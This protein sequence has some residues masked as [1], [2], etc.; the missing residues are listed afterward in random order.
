MKFLFLVIAP[1]FIVFSISHSF[2][3]KYLDLSTNSIEYQMLQDPE[4]FPLKTAL[5]LAA[6]VSEDNLAGY[7]QQL[8]R[9]D[10]GIK[11]SRKNQGDYQF[12]R[13]AFQ[14]MHSNLLKRYDANTTTLD[15]ALS[16]GVFNCLSSTA[17]YSSILEDFKIPF[18]I[19]V[20][21]THIYSTLNLEGREVDVENT[22]PYGFD[23][24]TNEKAQ[25][26]LKRN[27]GFTYTRADPNLEMAG[28]RGMIA[29]TYAN[30]SYFQSKAGKRKE[31]F[32]SA[33][34]SIVV[35][36]EGRQIYTNAVA[37]YCEYSLYLAD[38]EKKFDESLSILE[39]AISNLPRKEI[40]ITNYFYV[41]DKYISALTDAGKD[42]EAFAVYDK[43]KKVV[44]QNTDVEDALFFRI[45]KRLTQQEQ[46]YQKAYDFTKAEMLTNQM[47][48]GKISDL[49]RQNFYYAAEQRIIELNAL[50]KYE[51]A[52]ALYE[53]AVK[54]A[55]PEKNVADNL[56]AGILQSL[57]DKNA[58]PDLY[59]KYVKIA[60]AALPDSAAVRN[61]I[62]NYTIHIEEK[63]VANWQTYPQGLDGL[64]NWLTL[65]PEKKSSEILQNYFLNIGYHF[66]YSGQKDKG[67]EITRKGF[68][69]FPDSV[70]LKRNLGIFLYNL[71]AVS[72]NQHDFRKAI[73]Q[74]KKVLEV[75]PG[76]EQATVVLKNSYL[77]LILGMLDSKDY[78]GAKKMD[79]DAL[80]DFPNDSQFLEFRNVINKH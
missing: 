71:A 9:F 22:T 26:E 25:E 44:G 8:N 3:S 60:Q 30:L 19:M 13:T 50:G 75:D 2:V 74:A 67:I 43:A 59:H 1:L 48:R 80:K 53:D 4:R 61:T 32:Q 64:T 73:G 77:A 46:D 58:D 40:F 51:D 31:A 57:S 17:L 33:L 5:L 10:D 45:F 14:M 16:T 15:V 35:F 66:Y 12:A 54:T 47:N 69:L 62:I 20:L 72:F 42:S 56:Y 36:R 21:P 34:K 28:K 38:Y 76:N 68:E 65:V 7:L 70:S 37:S 18:F 23:I 29:Y 27:T 6:G 24:S 41:L 52:I 11:E 78:S 79:D 49:Y 39:D 55:G 63:L